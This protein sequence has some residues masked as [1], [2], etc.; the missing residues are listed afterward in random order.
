MGF[1]TSSD[2]AHNEWSQYRSDPQRTGRAKSR[3]AFR[4]APFTKTWLEA[5]GLNLAIQFEHPQVTLST[6]T[7]IVDRIDHETIHDI[8]STLHLDSLPAGLHWIELKGQDVNGGVHLSAPQRLWVERKPKLQL[9]LSAPDHIE[10]GFRAPPRRSC[11]LER[12]TSLKDWTPVGPLFD[13]IQNPI[14]WIDRSSSPHS[15]YY[16]LHVLP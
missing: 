3:L 12:S 9:Q 15:G 1:V 6:I 5:E 8:N 13:E 16:R 2:A 7:L 11:Q 10:I 4:G 14:T